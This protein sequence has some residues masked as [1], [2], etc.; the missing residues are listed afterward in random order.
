MIVKIYPENPNRKALEQVADVLRNDG[1]IVYPTDTVYA[2]GCSLRS[3]KAIERLKALRGRK[4]NDMAI[5]CPDLSNISLYARVDTPVFKL[6]KRNLPGP[7][8]F[9]LKA[10]GK[11]PDKFLEHRKNIGVRIPEHPIAHATVDTLGH[12]LVPAPVKDEDE[13]IEYTTDPELIHEKYRNLVDLVVNGGYGN[14]EASTVVDC[15]GEEFEIVRQG[16]G[17][18]IF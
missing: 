5:V 7:F 13:V 15:T 4:E 12:P 17:E 10:S 18:L 3:P 14:N 11:V 9:I 6:L 8:T 1:V 16:L 2:F